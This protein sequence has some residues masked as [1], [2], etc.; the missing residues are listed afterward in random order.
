VMLS[1]G[2][3]VHLAIIQD[4]QRKWGPRHG[5]DCRFCM[6]RSPCH[7]MP[8]LADIDDYAIRMGWST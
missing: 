2:E 4:H 3:K 7:A 5:A 6:W 1:L 8:S